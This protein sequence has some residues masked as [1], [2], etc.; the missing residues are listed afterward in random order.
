MVTGMVMI[1]EGEDWR[2]PR[3]HCATTRLTEGWHSEG[4]QKKKVEVLS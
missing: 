1:M 3:C 4:R 2:D